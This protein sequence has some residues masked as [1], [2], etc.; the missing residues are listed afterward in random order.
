MKLDFASLVQPF[1]SLT[2]KKR[3]NRKVR[4]EKEKHP[5]CSRENGNLGGEFRDVSAGF[6]PLRE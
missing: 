4:K 3:T 5:I 6:P 1:A 2:V